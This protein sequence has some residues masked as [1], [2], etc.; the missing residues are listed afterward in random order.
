M[1]LGWFALVSIWQGHSVW[2]APALLGALLEKEPAFHQRFG[3]VALAGIALSVCAGGV[4][5]ALFGLAVREAK[6]FPRV[7]LIGLLVGLGSYYLCQAAITP[8]WMLGG[9]WPAFERTLL[10][11]CLLY[12]A[13]LGKY[14]R[15]LRAV[16]RDLLL[17]GASGPPHSQ[18]DGHS[19]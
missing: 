17:D 8:A 3:L 7:L 6:Q 18:S 10:V 12:G 16:R 13:F 4:L 14:P 15:L 19:G 9:S 1:A 5:G 11:A 2:A